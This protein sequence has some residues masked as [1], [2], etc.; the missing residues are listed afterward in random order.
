MNFYS[1]IFISVSLT[2]LMFFSTSQAQTITET[3]K[4]QVSEAKQAVA[5]DEQYFYV[6]NNSTI[7]KLS[8]T[9]GKQI[10]K[11]DGTK[12]GIKHLNSGVVIKG[13]LYCANSNYP[14][15][16]MASSIEIFDTK[17]MQHIDNHS[18][19]IAEHGSLTWIDQKDGFWWIGFA[20]YGGKEASEGRDVRWTSLVKYDLEFRQLASWIFPKN[21]VELFTPKSN[22]GGAWGTDGLLYCTGHDKPE[23]YVMKL[24]KSGYTLE[25]VATLPASIYGQGIAIDKSVKGKQLIY[26][27]NRATNTV[28]VSEIAQ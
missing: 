22:S 17:T 9:D 28:T 21:I 20:H 23:L 25:H 1:A 8:K 4:F 27:L 15:I 10:A 12:D 6:I 2:T 7:L 24:P 13:K 19:G 18:F 26:G 3:R 5:V 16:P 14:E 11:W